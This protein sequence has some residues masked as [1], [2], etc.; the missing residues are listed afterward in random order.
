MKS[1][2]LLEF[3][4]ACYGRLLTVEFV[5]KSIKNS[6]VFIFVVDI[7]LFIIQNEFVV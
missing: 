5:N 3:S 7:T 6:K 2:N 1:T 4:Q